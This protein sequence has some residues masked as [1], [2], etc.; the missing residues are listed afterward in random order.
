MSK[1][2]VELV[3]RAIESFNQGGGPGDETDPDVDVVPPE[4]WPEG[5]SAIKGHEAW[6]RQMERLRDSWQQARLEIDEIRAVGPNRAV[7][8]F[9]YIA[10]GKDSGIEFDMAMGGL[11]DI[12]GG[13]IVRIQFF[14][15]PE[16][17]YKAA[18]LSSD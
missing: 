4:G 9:R 17:A 14:N 8:R 6:T 15:E 3:R 10:T 12:E 1:E 11:Y 13:R 2:N 16:D 18:G 7:S 5:G